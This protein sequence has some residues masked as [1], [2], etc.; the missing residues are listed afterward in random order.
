[1]NAYAKIR[2]A[3][4]IMR[5]MGWSG[6]ALDGLDAL[7]D[8]ERAASEVVAWIIGKPTHGHDIGRYLVW[9]AG[10]VPHSVGGA[11]EP[12]YAAPPAP[13]AEI[14]EPT[15]EECERICTEYERLLMREGTCGG[16]DAFDAVRAVMWPKEGES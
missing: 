14:R 13:V 3:L 6:A 5:D 15:P 9:N 11:A 2:A 16:R 8:L 10:H 4:E 7:A 12:L 1:V